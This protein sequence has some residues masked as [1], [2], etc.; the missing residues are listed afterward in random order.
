MKREERTLTKN[1]FLYFMPIALGFLLQQAYSIVDGL[2]LGHFAG[3]KALAAVNGSNSTIISLVITFF[4]GISSGP[5]VLI[6]Q[7]YG[8]G[9]KREVKKVISN[10]LL[11]SLIIGFIFFLTIELFSM[12][13]HRALKTPDDIINDS[14]KYI[15]WYFVGMVPALIFTMG[16]NMLRSFGEVKKPL[17]FLAI[18]TLSNAIFDM[19]FVFIMEDAIK[20][21]AIASALSQLIS[22]LLILFPLMRL[23]KDI[24]LSLSFDP[25]VIKAALKIGIPTALQNSMYFITGLIISIAINR[26]GT[27]SVAA[28]A[29]FYKYD[30]LYWAL[31]SSFNLALTALSGQFYGAK[32]ERTL[33]ASALNGVLCYLAVALPFSLI[34]FIFRYPLSMLFTS[35]ISVVEEASRIIG[36]I[37]LMY[38]TFAL[39]EILAAI[40]RGTGNTFRP[41]LIT[42]LS[43]FVLRLMMLF[44]IVL[45]APSD[46]A[47]ACC[48][49]IPWIASSVLFALYYFLGSWLNKEAFDE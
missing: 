15:K 25:F 34:L 22:A 33:R 27:E 2:V 47:I 46:F 28:W 24:A 8:K 37:A 7:A 36:Y 1:I 9:D 20:A 17:I 49:F 23:D 41:T 44:F 12:N 30:G 11:L 38:P 16:S 32:D 14:V 29:I 4:A 6:A 31:S 13:I 40:M 18:C 35:E 39:T 42:F 43:I 5:M 10:A 48:Y 45:R 21:V 19:L 26:L 3:A